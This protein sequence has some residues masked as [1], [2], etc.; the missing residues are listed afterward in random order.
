MKSINCPIWEVLSSKGKVKVLDTLM[1]VEELNITEIVRQTSLSHYSVKRYLTELCD[2]EL[3][4]LKKFGRIR[5]YRYK[6]ELPRARALQ[7]AFERWK[8]N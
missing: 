1:A 3:V 2:T 5:I 6:I 8:T 7:Y 4:E